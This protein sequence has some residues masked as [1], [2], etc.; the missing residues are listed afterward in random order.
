M[1]VF[2]IWESRFSPER[3]AEGHQVT[4]AIWRDMQGYAGYLSH[5]IVEDLDDPGHLIVVSEWQTRQAADDVLAKYA[6]HENA[7]RA[8][9]LVAEPRRRTLAR[10]IASGGVDR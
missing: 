3:R 7:K 8:N 6:G 4:E 1:S 5:V 10:P 9:D 2:S